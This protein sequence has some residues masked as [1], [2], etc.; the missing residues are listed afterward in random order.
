MDGGNK[1]N[2]ISLDA[3]KVAVNKTL[4]H[5]FECY[6]NMMRVITELF[7]RALIH[8]NSKITDPEFTAYVEFM[9]NIKNYKFGTPEYI[10]FVENNDYC[11]LHFGKNKHHP[12][13]Y[14]NGID[15][16]T[17][18]DIIEMYCDWLAC[19]RNMKETIE[20]SAKRFNISDQLKQIFLNT[21]NNDE[22]NYIKEQK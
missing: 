4:E 19:T 5:K 18:I 11:K 13:Y 7:D 9:Q 15:G 12:Q 6:K 10:D 8:D 16:M 3:K 2:E 14:E 20:S 17:L 22:G 1:M 21:M